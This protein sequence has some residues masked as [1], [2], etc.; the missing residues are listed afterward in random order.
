MN[1]I[2]KKIKVLKGVFGKSDAESA[3]TFDEVS[4]WLKAQPLEEVRP[5]MDEFM[6]WTEV[7]NE[8]E[9]KPIREQLNDEQYKLLPVGYIA[10]HYFGKSKTWLYQRINGTPVRGKRY[11]L[12][13]EQKVIFNNAVQDIASLISSY[14][15]V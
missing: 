7:Q 2:E 6:K 10:E 3:K 13:H 14:K 11:T 4:A 1:E 8:A 5:Y 9:M 15:I 12:N